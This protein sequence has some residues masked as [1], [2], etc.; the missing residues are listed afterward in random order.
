LGFGV[1]DPVFADA[2][3]LDKALG[4]F[5][6]DYAESCTH[7]TRPYPDVAETLAALEK[8]G[9]S[10]AVLTNKPLA[11]TEKILAEL[12]LA[13][14]VGSSVIAGDQAPAKPDP[15]GLLSL[16]AAAGATPRRTLMVGDM[17]V[18]VE[19]ARAAETHAAG[20]LYGFQPDRVRDA[21]PDH[22]LASLAD[23]VADGPVGARAPIP[24][25]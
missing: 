7:R 17:P 3:A 12:R 4:I 19:T 22:L 13:R 24:V 9:A 18:D 5:L 11:M 10:L 20:V 6:R 15:S 8:R 2:A 16:I 23:L 21:E 14:F 1:G 25:D